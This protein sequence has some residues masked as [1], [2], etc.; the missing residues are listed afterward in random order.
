MGKTPLLP[1]YAASLGAG[2]VLLG[3][4]VSVSTLT[5]MILKPFIGILSDR[6]GKHAWLILGTALFT[7]MPFLYKF[8]NTPDQLFALRMAHGLATAIYGPVTLAYIATLSENRR[9]ERLAWFNIARNLGY[10]VGP[11]A[12]GWMLLTMD[13]VAVFTSIGIISSVAFV[14][15]LMLPHTATTPHRQQKSLFRQASEALRAGARTPAIWLAGGLDANI[16]IALY[17]TKAFLPLYALSNGT[18]V[19]LAG[20]F[21]AVQEMVHI[22]TNPLAGRITDRANHKLTITVGMGLLGTAMIT[23]TSWGSGL[24]VMIS[25]ILMG[26]AQGLVFPSTLALVANTVSERQLGAGMGLVGALKNA[27]KVGGPVMTGILITWL[28][29]TYTFRSIGTILLVISGAF[30]ILPHL[31]GKR[32][33]AANHLED[34]HRLDKSR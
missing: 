34:S 6:W 23:L 24:T 22:C 28:D 7:G 4:I 16:N 3:F 20:A 31:I 5:G 9:A 14:P 32:N 10:V 12:A 29:F 15:V 17:A 26:T 11:I 21:F 18:S 8:V 2:D 27:G 25:A 19:A 1:L 30:W 33:S 13:H